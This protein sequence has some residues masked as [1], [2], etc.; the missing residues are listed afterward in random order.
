MLDG[1]SDASVNGDFVWC[2]CRW[3]ALLSALKSTVLLGD[4]SCFA[5]TTILAHQVVGVLIGTGSMIPKD[6]SLFDQAYTA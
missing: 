2:V 4:P 3:D 5:T 6:T 1:T